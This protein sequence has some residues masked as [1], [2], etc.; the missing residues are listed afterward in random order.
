METTNERRTRLVQ[1]AQKLGQMRVTFSR[2]MDPDTRDNFLDSN[3]G[4]EAKVWDILMIVMD[5]V[6]AESDKLLA[7]EPAVKTRITETW[8]DGNVSVS[9]VLQTQFTA[10]HIGSL[11]YV[12]IEPN[13]GNPGD[14][15]RVLPSGGSLT[16][17][18]I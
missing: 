8:S 16:I 3:N 2:T 14:K 17:E 4:P 9:D 5:A 12:E 6:Y 18:A 13:N 15:V 10:L 11:L 7:I 1:I